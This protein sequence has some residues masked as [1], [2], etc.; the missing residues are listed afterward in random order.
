MSTTGDRKPPASF[1]HPVEDASYEEM[2]AEWG[3]QAVAA[4]RSGAESLPLGT[5][6][7]EVRQR[8]AEGEELAEIRRLHAALEPHRGHLDDQTRYAHENRGR[9]IE[10]LEEAL[11]REAKARVDLREA[12]EGEAGLRAIVADSLQLLDQPG[13]DLEFWVSDVKR[14]LRAALRPAGTLASLPAD[15]CD[16]SDR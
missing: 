3:R 11:L 2:R 9:L 8:A 13:F 4:Q 10:L 7:D 14:R 5:I 12:R 15:E 16:G 6:P 1:P